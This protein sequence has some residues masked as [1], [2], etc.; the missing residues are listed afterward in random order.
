MLTLYTLI[1]YPTINPL[2]PEEVQGEPSMTAVLVGRTG[3]APDLSRMMA[4]TGSDQLWHCL[5][6]VLKPSENRG[7]SAL[8]H[9]PSREKSVRQRVGFG[10]E[11]AG[12]VTGSQ[13]RHLCWNKARKD[14]WSGRLEVTQQVKV[15]GSG[16]EC[17]RREAQPASPRW[18]PKCPAG[19]LQM[20]SFQGQGR[21]A[22]LGATAAWRKHFWKMVPPGVGQPSLHSC[23]EAKFVSWR[24]QFW[25]LINFP[26]AQ[27]V[28]GLGSTVQH[29]TFE[30]FLISSLYLTK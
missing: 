16:W 19:R 14:G 25:I 5:A 26:L 10:L 21:T 11:E 8:R 20:V 13:P 9:C 2:A 24:W 18:V 27:L 29:I 15:C 23:T 7:S 12:V 22:K 1:R 6:N 17:I 30:I 3:K 28:S 4:S